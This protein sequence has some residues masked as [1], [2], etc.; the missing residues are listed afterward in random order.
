MRKIWQYYWDAK[1]WYDSRILLRVLEP[2]GV[3]LSREMYLFLVSHGLFGGAM[4]GGAYVKKMTVWH[5][6]AFMFICSV[7]PECSMVFCR[8]ENLSSLT[9]DKWTS[10]V[11]L[12]MAEVISWAFFGRIFRA[13]WKVHSHVLWGHTKVGRV[14]QLKEMITISHRIGRNIFYVLWFG[15]LI[16][17]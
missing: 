17:T 1:C 16:R 9:L 14:C 6:I 12:A 7:G 2:E 15:F 3:K 8:K 4:E 10:I 11:T 5:Y 13:D